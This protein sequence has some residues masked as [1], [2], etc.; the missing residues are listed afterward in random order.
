MS[1]QPVPRTAVVTGASGG[2]GSAIV[3]LLARR[4][5]RVVVGYRSD[6]AGASELVDSLQGHHQALQVDIGDSASVDWF[7]R[8]VGTMTQQIDVLVNCA[9]FSQAVAHDRLEELSDELIDDIFRVNWRGSFSVIR[10]F[11]P[12][13][14]AGSDPVVVNISSIA[15]TTGQGSN[16]A[17]CAAKAGLDSMTRSLGRALAPDIR[18]ISVA[19]GWVEGEYAAAMDPDVLTIQLGATPLGRLATPD[20][21]ATAVACAIDLS[22]STGC[23][24]PV[25]GGRPLGTV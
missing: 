21:V 12:L 10:A 13:L 15:G 9:G 19:P 4:G 6:E 3:R 8:D 14:R 20:D 22:C 7:A 25:D 16:V 24:I 2:I 1:D 17:Y 18:V 11:A 5:L 23:V